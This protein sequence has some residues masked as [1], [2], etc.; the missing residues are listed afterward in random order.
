[1]KSRKDFWKHAHKYV[2]IHKDLIHNTLCNSVHLVYQ[3]LNETK[4]F[5]FLLCKRAGFKSYILYSVMNS[6]HMQRN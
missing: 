6:E 4:S 5:L 1:M 2:L 3:K